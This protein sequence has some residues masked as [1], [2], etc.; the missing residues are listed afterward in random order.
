M[1]SVREALATEEARP[2]IRETEL[3]RERELRGVGASGRYRDTTEAA[4]A[5]SLR[6]AMEANGQSSLL[7]VPAIVKSCSR[8][9]SDMEGMAEEL[10]AE[11]LSADG[12]EWIATLLGIV[13]PEVRIC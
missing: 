13:R 6:F 3:L 4:C 2:L 11:P 10:G 12:P 8:G 7:G 1:G 9:D 5:L